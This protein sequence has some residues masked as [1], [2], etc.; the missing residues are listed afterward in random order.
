MRTCPECYLELHVSHR[1][2]VEIDH[3]PQCRGIWLDHGE[4]EKLIALASQSP[5][6]HYQSGQQQAYQVHQQHHHHY[7][8]KHH[9]H[10][11]SHH[12]H[13]PYK[14]KHKYEHPVADFLEDVF[15]IF[16]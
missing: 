6:Q 14:K 4:L 13:K 5:Y 3:C 9:K 10:H 11:D 8:D 15:D 2:G 12:G 16:G 1:Q 7:H